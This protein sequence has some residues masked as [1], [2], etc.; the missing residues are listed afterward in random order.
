MRRIQ[1]SGFGL[2][3]ILGI[4]AAVVPLPASSGHAQEN[5]RAGATGGEIEEVLVTARKRE[6]NLLEIPESVLAISGDDIGRQNIKGLED[7]GFLAPNLNLSTRLDGFPNVSIR[8]LGSFGNTQG[9]GFYLDDVQMFSDAS[10]RFGDLERIEILKGPQGTLYGGSNIGGAI[11]FVSAR[12]DADS[13][14]GRIK[15]LVGEQGI[16]DVEGS[17]NAPVGENGWAVR[18]FG[19]NVANDGYL[20]NRNT[21]RT[22][23]LRTDNDPDVGE[24]QESGLRLSLA[25]AIAERLSAYASVRMNSFDGPNNTWIRELDPDRLEH[26][27]IV[28]ATTNPRHERRTVSGMLEL[29]LELDSADLVSVTSYTDTHSDRYS[30]L[31]I[32]EEYLLDLFRPEKM[33]VVTQELRLIS[34]GDSALQWLAGVYYSQFEEEMDADL[35]WFDSRALPDDLFSGPLGCAL[36]HDTCSGVWA[37]ETVPF[38]LEFSST[39][40]PFEKRQRDKS[41]LAVFAN[42][43]YAV[44]DWTFAGGLRIDQWENASEN[45]DTAIA[46]K[47]NATEVLPRASVSRHLGDDSMLYAT[48]AQGYEP[49]GFNL[50]NFEGDSELFG[51]N[52]ENATSF[53]VG[54]KGRWADG[55]G[56]AS[57]AVFLI[58]YEKR[59]IEYQA[60]G[61]DGG[62][63]EGIVNLGDSEQYGI[64]ADLSLRVNDSLNLSLSAGNVEA[65]WKSGTIVDGDDLKGRTPPVVPDFSWNAAADFRRPLG[66]GVELTATVQISH[67]GSYEGLQAWNPVTNPSFTLIGAQVGLTWGEDWELSLNGEN[68]ADESYYTDVQHF[69]NFFLLDG[70]E[71]IV[72]GTLGQPRLFTVSLDYA[73]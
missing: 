15:G 21:A 37:G 66:N 67:N 29:T 68:L 61:A 23:G 9:V 30:D 45:L 12:P 10:S 44:D 32:R 35:I 42:A 52:A 2:P 17:V 4:W 36:E 54:W 64:E 33:T 46:S 43:T 65:E 57:V 7:I 11:K 50:T 34:T 48:F 5:S 51:F 25:G 19:F 13:V 16:V 59:Q 53:E 41:H 20:V 27:D 70:G 6:E 56:T 1:L 24:S 62:V 40:T 47:Q 49:G 58:D 39:R 28:D 22:N 60:A 63:I 69:P 73:F 14:F 3:C 71:N 72:I 18:L 26:P 55:R 38:G 31:D 8:G